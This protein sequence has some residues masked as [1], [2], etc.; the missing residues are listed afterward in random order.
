VVWQLLEKAYNMGLIPTKKSLALMERIGPSAFCR[1]DWWACA[2]GKNLIRG[3]VVCSTLFAAV[4][5]LVFM[6]LCDC[7]CV[8]RR[9]LPVV[10]VRLKM[11]ETLKEAVTFIE[12]VHPLTC[13]SY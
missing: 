6:D 1:Y 5:G 9:R 12:Q 7:C 10:M 3:P 2:E 4:K 8:C 11:S 13:P